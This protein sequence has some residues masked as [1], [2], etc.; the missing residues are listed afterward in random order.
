MIETAAEIPVRE[1]IFS[2]CCHGSSDLSPSGE[3][4]KTD[5]SW[6]KIGVAIVLA[7]QGMIFGL[8]INTADPAPEYA[9]NTYLV[10]HGS[11]ILSALVVFI[12][13]GSELPREAWKAIQGCPAPCWK[14]L[15]GASSLSWVVAMETLKLFE[16]EGFK[17]TDGV[18]KQVQ[19]MWKHQMSTLLCERA[20][21]K[22][23]MHSHDAANQCKHTHQARG[24]VRA[25]GHAVRRCATRAACLARQRL[26]RCM[27]AC[28][29]HARSLT[30]SLAR[31]HTHTHECAKQVV[32]YRTLRRP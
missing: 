32:V 17:Y 2:P 7:G 14:R 25:A 12:L 19:R 20:F 22:C 3:E 23:R 18:D 31:M 21:Q 1:N 26:Q 15:V 27:C 13:L 24:R 5:Y 9:S 8:G 29:T 4:N 28:G 10:L 30:H 6:L 11:L 16:Q